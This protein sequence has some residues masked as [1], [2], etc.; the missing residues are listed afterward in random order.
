MA[1]ERNDLYSL[2]SAVSGYSDF[3]CLHHLGWH[4]VIFSLVLLLNY[5]RTTSA[6]FLHPVV[7]I[8]AKACKRGRRGVC[9]ENRRKLLTRGKKMFRSSKGS[10][11]VN[12]FTPAG[13]QT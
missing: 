5:K 9:K 10:K 3:T 8:L 11:G 2:S 6:S 13:L 4:L 12:E 1:L 7:F